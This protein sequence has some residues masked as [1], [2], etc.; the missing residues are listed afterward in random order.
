MSN[1]TPRL[2]AAPEP[3]LKTTG[4][5]TRKKGASLTGT[6]DT[7]SSRVTGRH[8]ADPAHPAARAMVT[9]H[10]VTPLL[11]GA[12]STRNAPFASISS[13]RR[14]SAG[15]CAS[16]NAK[17]TAARDGSTSQETLCTETFPESSSRVTVSRSPNDSGTT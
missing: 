13:A 4:E 10:T 14:R 1:A 5:E 2:V 16:E 8:D 3:G 12:T 11:S 17:C 9:F 7:A 15:P 6:M